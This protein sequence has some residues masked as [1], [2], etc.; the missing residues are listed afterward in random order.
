MYNAD[1][2]PQNVKDSLDWYVHEGRPTGGFLRSV[3]ANDLMKAVAKAD[4]T[5]RAV[6]PDIVGY[7]FNHVPAEAWG[8]YYKVESW[9]KKGGLNERGHGRSIQQ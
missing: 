1:N 4:M 6:L 9:V 5:N 8:S 3:L 2:V 7:V